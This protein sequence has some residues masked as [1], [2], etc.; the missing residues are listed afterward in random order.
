MPR[1]KIEFT[2]E[3]NFRV[4]QMVGVNKTPN[5]II[6][7]LVR[8]FG[9]KVSIDTLKKHINELGLEMIDNRKWN[10]NHSKGEFTTVEGTQDKKMTKY[11]LNKVDNDDMPSI[12]VVKMIG[13]DKDGNPSNYR[14]VKDKSGEIIDVEMLVSTES[15]SSLYNMGEK[16]GHSLRQ[17]SLR[18]WVVQRMMY[19]LGCPGRG[20]APG[21][22]IGD[23][24]G[25][26]ARLNYDGCGRFRNDIF[27]LIEDN[28][29]GWERYVVAV[30]E[31]VKSGSTPKFSK[32]DHNTN[33]YKISQFT[34]AQMI[35]MIDRAPVLVMKYMPTYL[36]G[37]VAGWVIDEMYEER[38]IDA[39]SYNVANAV[40]NIMSHTKVAT[41]ID[42]LTRIDMSLVKQMMF[43]HPNKY[44]ELL[45]HCVVGALNL[46]L[47][48]KKYTKDLLKMALDLN[49]KCVNDRN[50]LS[51]I[52]WLS[53][54]GP[55]K[56]DFKNYFERN[57]KDLREFCEENEIQ[58][59]FTK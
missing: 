26:R 39:D 52:D 44:T 4:A 48:E 50:T 24:R 12:D 22:E 8:T 42:E 6:D 31:S 1:K 2:E 29:K 9:F 58:W 27:D 11:R 41:Q 7:D 21:Q 59:D 28:Q 32:I 19:D 56:D 20:L 16:T 49:F 54:T 13:Y 45:T 34:D 57:D 40:K 3:M 51:G 46:G 53:V 18:W 14:L 43:L 35:D 5:E 38:R 23:W 17:G 30:Y 37:K 33:R 47:I 36:Y 10:G 25:V 55:H 15:I